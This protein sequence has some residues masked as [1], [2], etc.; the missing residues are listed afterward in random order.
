MT[1]WLKVQTECS[2]FFEENPYA[3]ETV[4]G[5]ADRLGRRSEHILPALNQLVALSILEQ[6]GT[7]ENALY[8]YLQPDQIIIG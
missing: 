1:Y 8:H 6:I 4:D 3:Y 2:L 7:E 5:L